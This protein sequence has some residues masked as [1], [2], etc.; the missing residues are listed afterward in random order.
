LLT[1]QG[2]IRYQLKSPYCDGI[3][4]VIFEPL[5]FIAR[6]AP[7]VPTQRVHLTR[8]TAFAPNSPYRAFVTPAR[9][10]DT[11]EVPIPCQRLAAMT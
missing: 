2:H 10:A 5:D 4:H 11:T 7:L 9:E 6:L 3:T 1:P 8:S